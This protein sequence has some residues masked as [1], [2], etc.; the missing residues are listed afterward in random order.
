MK[1][2]DPVK[3]NRLVYMS[4]GVMALIIM[5]ITLYSDGGWPLPRIAMT[6]IQVALVVLVISGFIKM[7]KE[8]KK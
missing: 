5:D 4:M 6:L 8:N 7:S 2:K 3:F 1:K